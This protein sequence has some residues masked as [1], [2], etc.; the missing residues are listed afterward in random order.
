M[1]PQSKSLLRK[2][3][4]S[5][6]ITLA[7][8][9]CVLAIPLIVYL[10][11]R[12]GPVYTAVGVIAFL[13]CLAYLLLR[14]KTPASIQT[15]M[16]STPRIYLLLNI[17]FFCL[18][19]YSIVAFHMRPELYTRP[20]GYFIVL[21]AM[22]A[23]VAIEILFLPSRKTA[24]YLAL[25]KIIVIG[26]SLVWSQLL[27][28]PSIV[29]MDPW[30]HQMFTLQI[31]EA[32]HIPS[33]YAY[34][35]LPG[36][37]LV[38]GATSL[39]TGLDYKM[40]TMFSVSLLQVVCATLFI[41]LLGKFIHSARAGLLAGLVLVIANYFVRFSY[42]TIPNAMAVVFIPI[43]IYLLFKLRQ[44]NPKATICL[45]VL[46]MAA[47]ILTH[48]VAAVMLAL[49]LF[50]IWLGFEAYKRL[51]YQ[52]VAGA[53]I[54]LVAAIL[55]TGATLSYWTFV[56]GHTGTLIK[57]VQTSFGVEY[58]DSLP[59]EEV[60]PPEEVI[61]P[62]GV[63]PPEELTSLIA[64]V[65][66]YRDH[67]VP[68]SERLFNQLG[69]LSFFAF[70]FI[71]AFV[72]FSRSLRNRYGFALVIAGL[73]ILAFNFFSIITH[74]G[75]LVDRWDYFLQVLLAIPLGIAFLWLGSLPRKKIASACL[76]G[77]TVFALAFLLVISLEANRDNRTLSPN[78]IV[79]Y[80]FTQSELG[81]MNTASNIYAGNITSDRIY[82]NLGSLPELDGRIGDI[83]NQLW[84]QDFTDSQDMLVLI[85][86]EIVV[87]PFMIGIWA[88]FRLD[89]NPREALTDQGFSKV[90]DCGSVSGFIK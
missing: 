7:T 17:S 90:Y 59:P 43:I 29:G 60:A 26:L 73:I 83:S 38:T 4:D 89:Y 75:F 86:N 21:A 68:F 39:I 37:H 12:V 74:R 1:S 64:A 31:L 44:E 40:A 82:T 62:E 66:Q 55:F 50:L 61:P 28:Y 30:Y 88:P 76:I 34:S 70:G 15:P 22:A 57:L 6:D 53:R 52:V 3:I 11:L 2:A 36:M 84:A 49:L 87:N 67:I 33:G 45:S 9:G 27:I 80:G 20:F 71:G 35:W 13:T 47:L 19:T 77:I 16:E 32:G 79:R 46:F 65:A 41:F 10:Q 78:T 85:R 5:P 58:F 23:V 51:K 14:R 25:F 42:W 8:L 72:M 48:T 69:L 54:F 24:T 18:L 56:S 81:A 63:F